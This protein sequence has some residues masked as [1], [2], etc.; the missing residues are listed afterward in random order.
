MM[1]RNL[2]LDNEEKVADFLNFKFIYPL[3]KTALKVF[4]TFY[5][6][7]PLTFDKLKL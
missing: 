4:F 1:R 7:Q 2:N 5:S 6:F 3:T